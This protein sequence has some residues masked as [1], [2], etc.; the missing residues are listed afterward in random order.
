MGGTMRQRLVKH[1]Q[2][3]DIKTKTKYWDFAH[4]HNRRNET[5]EILESR[6]AN[7]DV[8]SDEAGNTFYGVDDAAKEVQ[9]RVQKLLGIAKQILTVQQYKVFF[10]LTERTMTERQVAKVLNVSQPRVHALWETAREKLQRA[11]EQRTA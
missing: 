7:P 9:R 3:D 11:Y 10:F 4:R 1:Q 8:L 6:R 5:G 2:L